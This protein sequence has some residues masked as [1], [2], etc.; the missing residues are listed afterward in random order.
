MLGRFGIIIIWG[1]EY[2]EQ[3]KQQLAAVE[4]K[5]A[6]EKAKGSASFVI[7]ELEN[8]QADI[9]LKMDEASK[10]SIIADVQSPDSTFT[11]SAQGFTADFRALTSGEDEYQMLSVTTQ[12]YL[13]QQ[14][15]DHAAEV[16]AVKDSYTTQFKAKEDENATIQKELDESRA[17]LADVRSKLENA[18]NQ[19]SDLEAAKANAVSE[20]EA[21]RK[22][23]EELRS[24]IT[25]KPSVTN[26][27]YDKQ[28]LAEANARLEAKKTPVYDVK[29]EFRSGKGTFKTFKLAS[30]DEPGEII[31]TQFNAK[32]RE[33]TAAEAATFRNQPEPEAPT[34]EEPTAP[35]VA[36]EPP[37]APEVGGTFPDVATTESGEQ[38]STG[39]AQ[40]GTV[41]PLGETFED[42]VRRRLNDL[43]RNVY[44]KPQAE[45]A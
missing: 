44:G 42:E 21:L 32:Y 18:T 16:K 7:S 14:E 9:L 35:V 31:W 26:M 30:N 20:V 8:Q 22:Q 27:G 10:Q 39:E 19:I 37:T 23:I 38:T 41:A 2:V 5:I 33:V 15:S 36:V 25:D 24:Q 28:A 4:Q 11:L 3:L 29:E 40:P 12:L 6:E 17:D 13:A 43:E 45:A 1:Y 34:V